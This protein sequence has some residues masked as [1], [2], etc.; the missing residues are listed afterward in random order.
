MMARTVNS[1]DEKAA[2]FVRDA[3]R[4][5]KLRFYFAFLGIEIRDAADRL[6]ELTGDPISESTIRAWVTDLRTPRARSVP[7]YVLRLFEYAYPALAP[8]IERAPRYSG[9]DDAGMRRGWPVF[10]HGRH[11]RPV[12]SRSSCRLM[13]RRPVSCCTSLRR[14]MTEEIPLALLSG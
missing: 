14:P 3:V 13:W 1:T 4:R 7:G 8:V 5:R 11:S 2:G 9:D 12:S 10:G 6:T